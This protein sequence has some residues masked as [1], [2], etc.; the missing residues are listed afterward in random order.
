V[1]ARAVREIDSPKLA[2]LYSSRVRLG[3]L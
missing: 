2:S 1:T 3:L